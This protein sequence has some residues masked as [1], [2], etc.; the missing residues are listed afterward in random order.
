MLVF[1]KI[2]PLKFIKNSA[3]LWVYTISTC[4]SIASIP[5][6]MKV[7]KEKYNVPDSI[8]GFTIPLGSQMNTDGSVLLYACVI[9]FISQMIGQP[10]TLAQI[11]NIV[12]ISTIMSMGGGG[13]PGS[14]VVKLMAVVQAV[15]LPIEIVGVIAAFYRLFDMDSISSISGTS[16]FGTSSGSTSSISDK[17][18][19]G[20]QVVSATLDKMNQNGFG[21]TNSDYDFQKSVLS[22]HGRGRH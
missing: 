22:A 11:I 18:T 10:M 19:F 15:G 6:N 8:S 16:G 21:Q 13:I 7:A 12:F 2:N 14:G 4:S 3:E 1:A 5:V 17:Q 20:A 9:M